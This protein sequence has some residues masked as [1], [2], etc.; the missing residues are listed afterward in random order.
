MA[1]DT[2]PSRTGEGAFKKGLE[3]VKRPPVNDLAQVGLRAPNQIQQQT[4]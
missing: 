2:L 4:Y 1:D 3:S